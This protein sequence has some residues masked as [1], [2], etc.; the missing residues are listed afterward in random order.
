MAFLLLRLIGLMTHLAYEGRWAFSLTVPSTAH[1]GLWSVALPVLGGLVVGL[2]ARYGTEQ[3]RGHGIPEAI[4]AILERG[5]RMDARVALVKPI[6]S[7]VAIGT[8]GPFGAEGPIIMTGGAM[9]S[10][11]A[12]R[13][14]LS[15]MERRVLLV[16]GAAAGM[17]ATFGAPI[18]SVFLAVELLLFEWR[19]RSVLPVT[20]ASV[21]AYGVRLWL[22]GSGAVFATPV[23]PWGG[24]AWLPWALMVGV[25]AGFASGLL[26]KLVYVVEDAYGRLP[27]HWM[28]W[29]A[30]GGLAVGLGGLWDPAALGVG[31]AAI[32]GLDAGQILWGAALALLVTKAL[33]WAA[34]LASGTSGGVLA[35]LLL[36]GGALGAVLAPWLPG[37]AAGVWAT[38][39]MAAMLGGTMRA[40]FTA[41]IFAMETTHDWGMI[42]PVFLGA[43][44]AMAVTVLWVPR[45]ILTEKVARRGTHVA[46]EYGVHPLEGVAVT[47][48]MVPRAHVVTVRWDEALS[49]VRHRIGRDPASIIHGAYPVV[50]DG[51]SVVGAIQSSV[52]LSGAEDGTVAQDVMVHVP[53]VSPLAR[54]R[55]AVEAMARDRVPF[56]LV[57]GEDG[58]VGWLT[59]RD[60][61]GAW[62][63]T[64]SQEEDR[65]RV[66]SA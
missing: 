32:R 43:M 3:I 10:L 56:V 34:S 26:T 9:G 58:W 24:Y 63:E 29:P 48:L 52:L 61:L 33:I 64:L 49:A 13:L 31:Y 12:Q 65:E 20:V 45:S 18:A 23:L 62:R 36:M 4:Q 6:A 44:A 46:R 37:H 25:A 14:T 53:R 38:I 7:A 22:L 17:S 30:I 15:G 5:G 35:P 47:R 8:G 11:L 59:Q 66:P 42:L 2:L 19:P 27:I 57:D 60:L 40:P 16:A 54:A 41:T 21:V 50:D 1:L 51:G 55:H 28:W 39:G